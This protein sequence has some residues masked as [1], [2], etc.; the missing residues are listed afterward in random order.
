M[1]YRT[2]PP[3]PRLGNIEGS[4]RGAGDVTGTG[5]TRSRDLVGDRRAAS[6][7]WFRFSQVAFWATA[8]LGGQSYALIPIY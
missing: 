1:F 5:A 2:R 3:G 4:M 7:E 6:G 8:W